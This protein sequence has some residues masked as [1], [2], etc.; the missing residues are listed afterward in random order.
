MEQSLAT[1]P[2][3]QFVGFL[4]NGGETTCN[5]MNTYFDFR[6]EPAAVDLF[7]E[8]RE[9]VTFNP[10]GGASRQPVIISQPV[11]S[12]DDE[13]LGF[14]SMSINAISMREARETRQIPEAL[15][16]V[17]FNAKGE[18]LTA[19]MATQPL[20]SILPGNIDLTTLGEL[21]PRNFEARTGDGVI[22]YFSVTPIYPGEAFALASW[23]PSQDF[24]SEGS[25]ERTT[26]FFT[27]AMWLAG[28]MI[29]LSA[30]YF[31]AVRPLSALGKR[32]RRFASGRRVLQYDGRD[33]SSRELYT[34]NRI[35]EQ[36]ARKILRDEAEL[37]NTLHERGV[38]L[39]EVHHRVKNN[40]QLISSILNMELRKTDN[41]EVRHKITRLQSRLSG[42]AS[43]YRGLYESASFASVRMDTL[44]EPLLRQLSVSLSGRTDDTRISFALDPIALT[45]DQAGQLA[46]LS[47]EAFSNALDYHAANTAGEDYIQ[48]SLRETDEATIVLEVEN[49]ISPEE[50]AASGGGR[51][52]GA[53]LIDA[54][55]MQLEGEVERDAAEGR[56]RLT[57]GFHPAAFEA[58]PED[59]EIPGTQ[60]LLA[61]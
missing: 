20:E 13:F 39:R 41:P 38:L 11:Y 4:R 42:L 25:P 29:A 59:Q 6:A 3:T 2:D 28:L 61:R 5:S 49:S 30:L 7:A 47:V 53:Q 15:D 12:P 52:L 54:F 48:V 60:S 34:I 10:P 16:L 50:E 40:L 22:R 26:L 58:A 44:I 45:P 17:T 46:L 8:P 21:A 31:L 57:V 56:Y 1:I 19:D 23:D 51:S 27:I 33:T 55:A 37:E 43:V 36:M 24:L 18:L 32:M 14:V 35:F 9:S